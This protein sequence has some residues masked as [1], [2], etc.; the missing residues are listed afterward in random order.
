[1]VTVCRCP[2]CEAYRCQ[3]DEDRW[4]DLVKKYH[5]AVFGSDSNR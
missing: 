4:H 1:M 3:E 2:Q 5:E